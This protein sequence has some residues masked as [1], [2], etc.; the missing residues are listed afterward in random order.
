MNPTLYAVRTCLRR[1][2]IVDDSTKSYVKAN[3]FGLIRRVPCNDSFPEQSRCGKAFRGSPCAQRHGT[4]KKQKQTCT[5]SW[6]EAVLRC[7][8][9]NHH[10][11]HRSNAQDSSHRSCGRS[12]ESQAYLDLSCGVR[13]LQLRAKKK[14]AISNL[15]VS[16]W[17]IGPCLRLLMLLSL[18]GSKWN[19]AKHM[20]CCYASPMLSILHPGCWGWQSVN[21]PASSSS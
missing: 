8:Y 18:A 17:L 1:P 21:V 15:T 20:L 12:H 11:A 5:T 10:A 7:H 16:A 6:T 13:P 3:M 14:P 4:R 2:D 19:P 9:S